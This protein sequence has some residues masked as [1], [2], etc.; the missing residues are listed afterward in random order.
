MPFPDLEDTDPQRRL[1]TG[2]IPFNWS[3]LDQPEI[4]ARVAI[5]RDRAESEQGCGT[6][7]V[8]LARD[9]LIVDARKLDF[10]PFLVPSAMDRT[11][12]LTDP[13]Q[14]DLRQLKSALMVR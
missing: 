7:L 2:T 4:N 6:S 5:L 9:S 12:T 1:S 10:D 8:E 3:F 13:P 11:K 14:M